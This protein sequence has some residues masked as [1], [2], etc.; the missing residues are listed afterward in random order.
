V[1]D[2]PVCPGAVDFVAPSSGGLMRTASADRIGLY[3][4][5]RNLAK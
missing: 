2:N 5:L 3:A 4:A 1:Q